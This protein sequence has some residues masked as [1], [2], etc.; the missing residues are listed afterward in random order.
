M[1]TD[2]LL[3]HVFPTFDTLMH[4][5]KSTRIIEI[6]ISTWK[7]SLS[8]RNFSPRWI[9]TLGHILL[10][11]MADYPVCFTILNNIISSNPNPNMAV[12]FLLV[13]LY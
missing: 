6:Y 3:F 7:Y 10:K 11:N 9:N 5:I 12:P 13:P 1:V 2:D 8:E 4:G